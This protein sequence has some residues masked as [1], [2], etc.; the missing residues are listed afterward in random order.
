MPGRSRRRS[1][2]RI[3][4]STLGKSNLPVAA[5]HVQTLHAWGLGQI[6]RSHVTGGISF[7]VSPTPPS[8]RRMS[9]KS[10]SFSVFMS[11][12]HISAALA[13]SL[14]FFFFATFSTTLDSPLSG[15]PENR[16]QHLKRAHPRIMLPVAGTQA[17]ALWLGETPEMMRPFLF[18]SLILRFLSGVYDLFSLKPQTTSD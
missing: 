14:F 5:D 11:P 3:N 12:R 15:C 4:S 8:P 17:A 16:R 7:Q 13:I 1:A 10:A 6:G 2:A 9:W 18:G